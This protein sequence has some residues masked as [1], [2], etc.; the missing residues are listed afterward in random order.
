MNHNTLSKLF[1]IFAKS[2]IKVLTTITNEQGR[3]AAASLPFFFLSFQ[4]L[5]ESYHYQKTNLIP[6]TFLSF[7]SPTAFRNFGVT[8]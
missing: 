8:N 3:V 4:I 1:V 2:R 5:K 7:I 6:S